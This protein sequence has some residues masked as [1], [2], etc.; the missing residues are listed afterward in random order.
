MFRNESKKMKTKYWVIL[1][2]SLMMLAGGA[3]VS[4]PLADVASAIS[5]LLKAI[6]RP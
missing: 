4:H 2:A 6:L 1:A 5:T 3:F